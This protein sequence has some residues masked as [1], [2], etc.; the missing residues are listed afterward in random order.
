MHCASCFFISL[1]FATFNVCY[2]IYAKATVRH[3][4]REG[5]RFAITGRTLNGSQGTPLGQDEV[6][7]QVVVKNSWPF[8]Q[9]PADLDKI[10][11]EY[12]G[13]DGLPTA[14]NFARNTVAIS[15][16]DYPVFSVVSSPLFPFPGVFE[17]D[18]TA[19]DKVEPFPGQPVL[20]VLP[21][22]VR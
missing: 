1:I 4:V 13:A 2:W 17:V 15:V 11:I 6:I 19:V 14:N 12:F 21:P 20:R 22:P 5:V 10:Q 8:V 18:A 9:S 3:G 16:A 7:K